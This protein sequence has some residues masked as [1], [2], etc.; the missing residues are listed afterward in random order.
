MHKSPKTVVSEIPKI[1]VTSDSWKSN[2]TDAGL[3]FRLG[4]E[5]SDNVFLDGTQNV[6]KDS[7]YTICSDTSDFLNLESANHLNKDSTGLPDNLLEF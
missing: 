5:L 4:S 3:T 1:I 6:F 7:T 2:E